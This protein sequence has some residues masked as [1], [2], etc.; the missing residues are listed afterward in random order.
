MKAAHVGPLA[1]RIRDER[2]KAIE[3]VLDVAEKEKVDLVIVAGDQFED[4]AVD[5]RLVIRVAKVLASHPSIS[6]HMIPGNH[7]PLTP[8]S[9]YHDHF[10]RG[11]TNVTVHTTGDPVCLESLGT[12]LHPCPVR[13]KRSLKDP[14]ASITVEDDG[15][16]HVGIAHGNLDIP[17]GEKDNDFPIP[18][19]VAEKRGLA[20]LALGHWHSTLLMPETGATRVAYSGSPETT[21]F[22]ERDS[23]NVLIVE[24]ASNA[25]DPVV[26]KVPTGGFEWLQWSETVSDA[27][28][29]ETIKSKVK[30]LNRPQTT[31][32]ELLLEGVADFSVIKKAEEFKGL[33]ETSV[34]FARM[35]ASGLRPEP[36]SEELLRLAG[37]GAVGSAAR[38]LL[39]M[40]AS[41]TSPE[42]AQVARRAL[43]NLYLV[44]EEAAR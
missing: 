23:G 4:N 43:N 24:I 9:V 36:T 27:Q 35:D 7:D 12:T 11:A 34:A 2:I 19:D 22:G 28:G 37:D 38:E 20:Y 10:W 16:I 30:K 18:Q 33:L 44:L 32:L 8:D 40:S 39:I 5:R 3:R 26:R 25:Y 1:E 13:E 21:K 14:T 31:L 42:E 17:Y 41:E 6:I 29:I 15:F